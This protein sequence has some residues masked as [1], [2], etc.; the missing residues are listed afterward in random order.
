MTHKR[1]RRK[2]LP[3]R[4]RK[5]N[6]RGGC[7]RSENEGLGG[8]L[9]FSLRN[10]KASNI[11]KLNEHVSFRSGKF[12]STKKYQPIPAE[13]NEPVKFAVAGL[14]DIVFKSGKNGEHILELLI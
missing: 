6:H 1:K 10:E 5:P 13:N 11:T 9:G 3:R 7:G 2:S 4:W 14:D 12:L 8:W